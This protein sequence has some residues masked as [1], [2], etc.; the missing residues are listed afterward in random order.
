MNTQK[1][2]GP[3]AAPKKPV[4]WGKRIFFSV[5]IILALWILLAVRSTYHFAFIWAWKMK[6]LFLVL[7]LLA[8]CLKL[9]WRRRKTISTQPRGK[10]IALK[11]GLTLVI[12]GFVASWETAWVQK[13]YH[14]AHMW[15]MF[16]AIPKTK[17]TALP[18]TVRERIHPRNNILTM[19]YEKIGNA[20]DITTPHLVQDR[21]VDKVQDVWTMAA[22]PAHSNPWQRWMDDIDQVFIVPANQANPDFADHRKRV[23]FAAGQ[24]MR[25]DKN[26]TVAAVK[27]LGFR[28]F[29][30]EPDEAYFM[31]NDK[32]EMVEVVTLI[33]WSGWLFPVP[34]FGGVIVIPAGSRSFGEMMAGTI[35]GQGHYLSPA[36]C[37]KKKYLAGN[38]ILSDKVSRPYAESFMYLHGYINSQITQEN[39]IQIPHLPTDENEF[40]FVTNCSWAGTNVQAKDGLYD[41]FALEPIKSER[42]G[43]VVSVFIPADGTNMVY[44][45]D[46]GAMDDGLSGVTAMPAKIKNSDMHIDWNSNVPV[47]FRPYIPNDIPE[48]KPPKNFF[49]LTTVVA[50]RTNTDSTHR[51]QFDGAVT[52]HIAV[53]NARDN[54]VIWLDAERPNEWS[55]TIRAAYGFDTTKRK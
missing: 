15:Y 1:A 30:M 9:I 55:K 37:R 41:Y 17:L 35:I 43:L 24:T 53:C 51:T 12:V 32:G 25:L 44:Y 6:P 16:N 33:Q 14:E 8:W 49:W 46:H 34:K 48:L 40:P 22:E 26:T 20:V 52:P 3:S 23:K 11:V 21:F 2:Q 31:H 42:T 45:Y 5:V 18:T 19:A 27:A 50:L 4:N 29:Y 47:E 38:N 13:R 36:E 28:Y 54:R 39:A 7:V 10:R